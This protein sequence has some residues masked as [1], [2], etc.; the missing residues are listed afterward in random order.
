MQINHRQRLSIAAVLLLTAGSVLYLTSG[1]TGAGSDGQSIDLALVDEMLSSREQTSAYRLIPGSVM[2]G[3]CWHSGNG[4][5]EGIF[6]DVNAGLAHWRDHAPGAVNP[7][8]QDAAD[9]DVSVTEQY[10]GS[11]LLSRQLDQLSFEATAYS[12]TDKSAE[13]T[14]ELTIGDHRR[15]LVL[16]MKMP[17]TQ[18]SSPGR[19]L[20]E[21]TAFT[22][23]PPEDLQY[24]LS[25]T[26]DRPLNLCITMQAAKETV[27]PDSNSGKPLL[28]SHYY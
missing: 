22:V 1:M 15:K 14:G 2:T 23:L 24:A 27:L 7:A 21:L 26:I 20:L 19:N 12:F 3:L 13:L 8:I 17:A 6:K 28:L 18:D 10:T 11:A 5:R 16:T 9:S 4:Y 25:D